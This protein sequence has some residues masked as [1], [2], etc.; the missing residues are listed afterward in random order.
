MSKR[1]LILDDNE[2]ILLPCT[3]IFERAGYFV[4]TRTRCDEIIKDVIDTSP[5]VILLDLKIPSL[6]GAQAIRHLKENSATNKIPVVLF[7]ATG[8]LEDIA[9]SCKADGFIQKPFDINILVKVV[10]DKV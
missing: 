4:E 8:G 9:R 2:D 5:D 3:F 6:G 1:I 10:N 7:S